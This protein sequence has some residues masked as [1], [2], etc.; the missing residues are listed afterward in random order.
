MMMMIMMNGLTSI[1]PCWHGLDGFPHSSHTSGRGH[2]RRHCAQLLILNIDL[3]V[4]KVTQSSDA[5]FAVFDVMPRTDYYSI[6]YMVE[7]PVM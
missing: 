6:A 5:V 7:G 3:M 2:R 4:F 1:F